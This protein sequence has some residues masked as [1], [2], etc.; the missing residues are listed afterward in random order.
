MKYGMAILLAI[1]MVGLQVGCAGSADFK[2][3][4]F[5]TAVGVGNV[6]T[7][8]ITEESGE[9]ACE[10]EVNAAGFSNTIGSAIGSAVKGV[11]GFFVPG[12]NP[13]EPQPIVINVPPSTPQ[14]EAE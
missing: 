12:S 4:Q 7:D 5:A 8:C 9:Y 3:W 1:I 10:Q 6:G 11:A 14:P 13:P 2:Q